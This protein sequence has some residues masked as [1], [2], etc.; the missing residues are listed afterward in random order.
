M[1]PTEQ[2]AEIQKAFKTETNGVVEALAGTGKTSTLLLLAEA[3]DRRGIII[4]YNKDAQMDVEA[5]LKAAGIHGR[6]TARTGHSLAFGKAI[7][8]RTFGNQPRVPAWKAAQILGVTETITIGDSFLEPAD[9][10]R[11]AGQTV[12]RFCHSADETIQPYHVPTVQGAEEQLD[13]IRMTVLKYAAKVWA[14]AQDERGKLRYDHDYYLKVWALSHPTIRVE[15][16]FLDEAQDT[17]PVLAQ[18]VA[19]QK[20]QKVMVGDR[21]QAIYG[22]R[23]AQDAMTNFRGE[24]RLPLTQS[25]R[26]GQA[27]AD[28]A[29]KWLELL[30]A[31]VRLQ[32]N[33]AQTSTVDI[34]SDPKAILCRT[35]AT[36][37]GEALEALKLGKKVALAGGKKKVAPLISFIEAANE[38]MD[39]GRTKHP[40]L[41]AF[42]S[43]EEVVQHSKDEDGADLRVWVRLID[44]YGT[45]DLLDA[46]YQMGNE[47]GADLIVSTSHA[48]KGREWSTVRIATDFKAPE[49]GQPVSRTDAMLAY[50]AVTRARNTLDRT[51]LAW[52]DDIQAVAA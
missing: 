25:W 48:A 43:W 7:K 29:N 38:L 36:C 37:V 49:D 4:T 33:P 34:L 26:F 47:E 51:G 39:S 16:L 18:V 3:T 45:G 10:A 2:Q 50:V 23:G 28:E 41:V 44:L 1:K 30:G 15:F 22:W 21:Y 19:E 6:V 27:V 14:D 9:I 13:E 8:S 5:K 31:D 12:K 32:G 35:N 11:L 52:V 42:R 24:W 20:C 17:N 40:E 46:C